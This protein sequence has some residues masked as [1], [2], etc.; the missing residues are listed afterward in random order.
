M[1]VIVNLCADEWV[2]KKQKYHVSQLLT[3]SREKFHTFFYFRFMLGDGE[4][5][6][7]AL[8]K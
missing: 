8:S 5:I 1:L 4:K 2:Y 6:E 3:A 7:D